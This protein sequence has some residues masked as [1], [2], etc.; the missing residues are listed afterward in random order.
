MLTVA[1]P[2]GASAPRL[3]VTRFPTVVWLPWLELTDKTE[4]PAGKV[5]ATVTPSAAAG[6]R[7]VTPR[8]R[9]RASPR[10]AAAG[11]TLPPSARSAELAQQT[12]FEVVRLNDQPWGRLPESVNLSSTM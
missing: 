12:G 3:A 10:L 2:P 6:P 5:S 11:T 1:V 9:V 4:S 7:L 8:V